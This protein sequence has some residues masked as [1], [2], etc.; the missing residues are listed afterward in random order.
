MAAKS[1]RFLWLQRL[2][3]RVRYGKWR[4]SRF[5]RHSKRPVGIVARPPRSSASH[6]QLSIAACGITISNEGDKPQTNTDDTDGF[7]HLCRPC[8]FVLVRGFKSLAVDLPAVVFWK[9]RHEF[10]PPRIFVNRDP[11]LHKLLDLFAE[12]ITAF[13]SLA[14]NYKRFRFHQSVRF[15]AHDGALE[16]RVML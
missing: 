12:L 16:N 6:L 9:G 5:L 13:K 10:Y 2:R 14:Q 3:R 4:G 7:T 1:P 11:A 8:L 15:V